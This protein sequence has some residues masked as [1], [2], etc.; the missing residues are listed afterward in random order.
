MIRARVSFPTGGDLVRKRLTSGN[1][2]FL[3]TLVLFPFSSIII[4][5]CHRR[6]SCDQRKRSR[7]SIAP[8]APRQRPSSLSE[9]FSVVVVVAVVVLY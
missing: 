2:V 3:A 5:Y 9:L 1:N 4:T 6:S 7:N 8:G